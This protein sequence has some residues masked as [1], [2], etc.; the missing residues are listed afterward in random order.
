MSALQHLNDRRLA[1]KA[2]PF[3]Q[4]GVLS[5]ADLAILDAASRRFTLTDDPEIALAFAFA[6][7]APRAGHVGA[8]VERLPQLVKRERGGRTERVE[9]EQELRDAWPVDPVSWAARVR[10]HEAVSEAEEGR[11]TPFVWQTV[12][13][14]DGEPMGLLTSHRMWRTQRLL[15]NDLLRLASAQVRAP[16]APHWL[17]SRL[18]RL[19]PEP[20]DGEA[21]GAAQAVA[22]GGLSVITGGPGTGK[23]W[24]VKLV[25]ALLLQH[26]WESDRPLV[27]EL[28]APTGKAAVRMG[29]ALCADLDLLAARGID[30]PVLDRLRGLHARTLHRLLGALPH[31]PHRFAHGAH[32]PLAADVVVVDEAS[33]IDLT[34]M[35]H[36]VAAMAAGSRLVLLGDRD[37][38]SSV[39]AGTVLADIVSGAGQGPKTDGPLAKRVVRLSRSRRFERAAAIACVA[40]ALQRADDRDLDAAVAL[41]AGETPGPER[42]RQAMARDPAPDRL[43]HHLPAATGGG[44]SLDETTVAALVEPW[45]A[46]EVA[47][48]AMAADGSLLKAGPGYAH[49][50]R[51][52]L[53]DPQ[54]RRSRAHHAQ[55]LDA[56]LRYR[57]LTP[58][59]QGARGVQ[60]LNQTLSEALQTFLISGARPE[61]KPAKGEQ[62]RRLLTRGAQWHGRPLLITQNSYEVN[63]RNGSVGLVVERERQDGR[64]GGELVALFADEGGATRYLPLARLPA[65]DTALAMTVHKSQGSEFDRVA[66]VLPQDAASPILT[67]ELLYTAL[68]RARWQVAWFGD[69]QVMRSCLARR[70]QRASGL[71]ELLWDGAP[72]GG[73]V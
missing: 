39:E 18:D 47:N 71:A 52:A 46:P 15:A 11:M 20:E 22:T 45:L 2:A 16:L 35:G 44:G 24:S 7:R 28:A 8:W 41:L 29:E 23:T 40:E 51:V 5:I 66:L 37:Q 13:A 54:R 50:L 30:A 57:V 61:D 33:M 70:I 53:P 38:L 67:R 32:N 27:V 69:R 17:A 56:L 73:K 64:G 43:H 14:G 9:D 4:A 60:G 68:T 31:A 19:F 26:A 10:D 55:L 3:V 36:L 59:R 58:H 65:H 25:L 34:M 21:R 72:A 62:S 48:G 42:W 6:L 63:L 12:Q 49:L 1:Q